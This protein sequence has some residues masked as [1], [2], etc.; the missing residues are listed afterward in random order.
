MKC[1]MIEA[2]HTGMMANVS[3]GGEVSE[4]FSVTNGVKQGCVL[5]PSLFSIFL[6][7]MLDE[8]FRD[9]ASTYSPDRA[10]TYSTSHT[11]EQRPRLLESKTSPRPRLL[12]MRE[13]LFA[14]DSALVA[15]CAEEMQ[16]IVDTFSDASKKFGLKINIK[17]TEVLYQ[18]NS[19]RTREE[20]IMVDGYK[21][22]SVLK[23]TYLGST[24]SSDG[25]IDDE[26]QR[27]MAKASASFGRLR[28]RLWNNHHVPMRV[29][30]KIYCAIVL[31]TLLYGAEAWTVYRRQVKK[32]HAFMMRHLRSIMRIT[33][34][35]KVTNKDIL[36]RTG[37]PSIDQKES[38]VDWTP[39]EDVTRQATEAGSLLPTVFWSQKERAPSSPIQGYINRNLK[40]RDIKIDS[41]TSLSQQRDKWR[42]T[43]K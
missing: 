15:H 38:P 35:D 4:S 24:I 18:P 14:D 9:M 34:M 41:C 36:E 12:L 33:W 6:S 32:L 30:G 3:V 17:K 1:T 42:A 22:N 27:R 2:L 19:T 28:Q 13:L 29:K 11:S 20:D 31:S 43:V 37:L 40:M 23:F 10:L 21:L 25:C 8:A 26:I 5:S 7:A 39:H 16:K